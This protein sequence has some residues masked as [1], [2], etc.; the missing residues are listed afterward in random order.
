M[1]R[2]DKAMTDTASQ[3][4]IRVRL[5]ESPSE[6]EQTPEQTVEYRWDRIIAALVLTVLLIG[7]VAGISI[8][9]FDR[10]QKEQP[11]YQVSPIAITNEA[12]DTGAEQPEP[13]PDPPEQT[14]SVTTSS[15][16]DEKEG[17]AGKKQVIAD[18]TDT[19]TEKRREA[20]DSSK[21]VS[22]TPVRVE[23]QA[24]EH[25]LNARLSTG[26]RNREPVDTAPEQIA[27]NPEGLIRLFL[28]TELKDLKGENIHHD[29]YRNGQRVARVTMTPQLERLKAH[30]SK[31]INTNMRGDWRVEVIKDDGALLAEAAFE[32]R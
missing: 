24:P 9:L 2:D 23:T 5:Q 29:W 3:L 32:V 26:I 28:F 30:S 22:G 4:K 12:K 25:I 21:E 18:R 20:A 27:M 7:S 1:N 31:Y 15:A 11:L 16:T 14:L 19:D 13:E 10:P 17:E 8:Y 6:A